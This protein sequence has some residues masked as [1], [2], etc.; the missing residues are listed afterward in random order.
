[1][2]YF[3]YFLVCVPPILPTVKG[4]GVIVF[5]IKRESL[6]ISRLDC[7]MVIVEIVL[8]QFRFDVFKIAFIARLNIIGYSV[9]NRAAVLLTLPAHF[10]H[11]IRIV[12]KLP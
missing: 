5:N 6:I 9:F 1:M 3:G 12:F 4:N 10:L 8:V 11:K 2:L 7:D